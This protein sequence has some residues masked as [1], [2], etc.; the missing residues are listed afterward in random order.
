MTS[1]QAV[2]DVARLRMP[3]D[4]SA[5]FRLGLLAV[6]LPAVVSL[7]AEKTAGRRRL[8]RHVLPGGSGRACG[9]FT[10]RC[11]SQLFHGALGVDPHVA[12]CLAPARIRPRQHASDRAQPLRVRGAPARGGR[13]WSVIVFLL[14]PLVIDGLYNG[15]VDY[16]PILG[17][18]LPPQ[19]GLF[20]WW[21]QAAHRIGCR[22]FL[23][24]GGVA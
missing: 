4:R 11:G 2:I 18:V 9:A 12:A 14:S 8:E 5:W 15:N 21:A 7:G 16:L 6:A 13:T 17:F 19:I 20:S 24:L 10:L 23:A 1:L 22:A 3:R